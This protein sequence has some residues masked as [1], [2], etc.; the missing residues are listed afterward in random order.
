MSN[1]SD[2]SKQQENRIRIIIREEIQGLA[3]KSEV[4]GL[5]TK[6]EFYRAMENTL[7]KDEFYTAMD[8]YM[9][10]QQ[11]TLDEIAML[12]RASGRHEDALE[13]LQTTT[14]IHTKEIHKLKLNIRLK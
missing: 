11:N 8:R 5:V 2:L 10:S 3:T 7:T 9:A 4:R 1:N 12:R 14:S 13:N 6:E